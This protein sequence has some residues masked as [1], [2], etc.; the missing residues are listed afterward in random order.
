M[1]GRAW[2]RYTEEKKVISRLKRKVTV[3]YRFWYWKDA[4]KN[5]Y[6]KV[7]VSD[8]LETQEYFLS[9]TTSTTIYDS[10]LKSKYSPNKNYKGTWGRPGNTP[11]TREWNRRYLLK[12]LK[13][14]GLK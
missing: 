4:N 7:L 9:K 13:E 1:R 5:S 6:Q 11:D 2:R 14:N 12:I 3:Y 8:Y 10:R